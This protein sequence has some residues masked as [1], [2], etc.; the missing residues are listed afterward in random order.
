[1]LEDV[2]R[3]GETRDLYHLL[4]WVIMPNHVHAVFKPQVSLAT[5]M[6]WL[7]GRTSRM[8]NRIL[9]RTG[10][11]FWQEES[12]DHWIR[13]RDELEGVIHYVENNPVRAG[14]TDAKESWPW[15]SARLR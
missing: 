2:L 8:A 12:F 3:Y 7:K 1:M 11:P 6:R 4:A 15:S 10:I 9:R 14:L 13:T 5:I